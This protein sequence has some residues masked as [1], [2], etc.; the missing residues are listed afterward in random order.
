MSLINSIKNALKQL[1]SDSNDISHKR[2]IAVI[3]F[4][5]L[6]AMVVIKALGYA[7]DEHLIYVFASLVGGQ[8]LLTVIDK[9]SN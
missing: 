3:S 1:L 4:L 7:V 5:V 8:S 2:V 9:F 6:I